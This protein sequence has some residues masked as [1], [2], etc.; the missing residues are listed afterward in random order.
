MITEIEDAHRAK[1][2]LEGKCWHEMVPSYMLS[3]FAVCK[4]CDEFSLAGTNN[5]IYC[6]KSPDHVCHYSFGYEGLGKRRRYFI[7]TINEERIHDLPE[8]F[9]PSHRYHDEGICIF[10]GGHR[11]YE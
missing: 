1:R 5:Q 11:D 6:E 9:V 10:C 4:H 2:L 8:D 3:K 7:E